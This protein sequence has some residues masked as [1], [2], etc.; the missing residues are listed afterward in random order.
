MVIIGLDPHPGTHTAA[1]LDEQGT[2]LGTLTR[3]NSPSGIAE[4]A[5]WAGR[6]PERLWAIEGANN[7]FTR[8]LTAHLVEA[9]ERLHHVHPG[10]TS[11]Y[12]ARRSAKKETRST[13]PTPPWRARTP[14]WS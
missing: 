1:A 8:Q 9:G 7:P 3:D 12:R 14:C 6:F 4:L 10:L 2:L 13:P 5:S 11:Q